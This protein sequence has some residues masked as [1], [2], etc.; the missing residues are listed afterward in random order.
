M[1]QTF[2]SVRL[3]QSTCKW[4]FLDVAWDSSQSAGTRVVRI[5]TWKLEA[6][7]SDAPV[8]TEGVLAFQHL[9]LQKHVAS[10]VPYSYHSIHEP[11][12]T[13][14]Q[15]HGPLTLSVRNTNNS[16]T[17]FVLIRHITLNSL[18]IYRVK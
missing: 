5:L 2:G 14:E 13:E 11:G 4:P 3:D 9:A 1:T 17:G 10:F 12:Q 8:K 16:H 6:L 15:G 7:R 18:I